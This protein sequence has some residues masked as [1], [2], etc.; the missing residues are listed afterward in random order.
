MNSNTYNPLDSSTWKNRFTREGLQREGDVSSGII[1][2]PVAVLMIFALACAMFFVFQRKPTLNAVFFS[3]FFI[4][5]VFILAIIYAFAQA[6]DVVRKFYQ[7]PSDYAM[8]RLIMNKLF[9]PQPA[10][11]FLERA[12][13][14]PFII[15]ATVDDLDEDNHARW[16]GGPA[17][18]IIYDGVAVYLE[19]GNKF[20]R[21]L[22][23][24]LPAPILEKHERIKAIVD[25]RPVVK[26]G[27]VEAWTKDGVKV[28]ADL[29]AEVQILSSED[30]KQ[31][32][33]VLE[34]GQEAVN[35]VYPFDADNVK[36]IVEKVAVGVDGEDLFEKVWHDAAIG[37]I[38]GGV[39]A[40]ISRYS[41]NELI[42]RD[43]NSPQLLS[44]QTSNELIENLEGGLRNNNIVQLL[45]LQITE[46]APVDEDIK[47]KLEEYWKTKKRKEE[48]IRNGRSEAQ[49]IRVK[50]N[51]YTLAYQEFLNTKV[52]Q[53]QEIGQE[54]GDDNNIDSSTEAS[55]IFLTQVFEKST[56]DPMLGTF[57]AREMLKTFDI[58]REQLNS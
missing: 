27:G 55:V 4:L 49:N 3:F 45:D 32:S 25:L 47:K 46:F 33:V 30:A 12:A 10:P 14:F 26:Y 6:K 21:V 56:K 31:R 29:Q 17:L 15:L 13:I 1:T 51:A 18:L 52:R 8:S 11:R 28:K 24:G 23:P 43:D 22:G 57:L 39:K 50:Q 44:F 38:E 34:K 20:S 42:I 36:K 40:H 35:L 41:L 2:I 16:F 37:T 19:R 48:A 9:I 54:S 53:L 5:I 58:L 7:L